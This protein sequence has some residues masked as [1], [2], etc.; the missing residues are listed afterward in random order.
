MNNDNV[1]LKRIKMLSTTKC[2]KRRNGVDNKKSV[3]TKMK[4]VRHAGEKKFIMWTKQMKPFITSTTTFKSETEG[5]EKSDKK[6]LMLRSAM[7]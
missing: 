4:N 6:K 5:Q 2:V 7:S 1:K 3:T